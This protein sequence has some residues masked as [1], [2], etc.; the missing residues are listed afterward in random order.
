MAMFLDPFFV[1]GPST[2]ESKWP[3]INNTILFKLNKGTFGTVKIIE[4]ELNLNNS[5]AVNGIIPTANVSTYV[6]DE[7]KTAFSSG[8]GYKLMSKKAPIFSEEMNC[9]KSIR[10]WVFM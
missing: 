5:D 2:G 1:F 6:T 3:Q 8:I 10:F 9:E 4:R 7:G